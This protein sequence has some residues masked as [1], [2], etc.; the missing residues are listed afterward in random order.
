M[1]KNV[2]NEVLYLKRIRIGYYDLPASLKLGEW[3]KYDREQ[4]YREILKIDAP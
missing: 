3:I 2:N 4:I 1:F